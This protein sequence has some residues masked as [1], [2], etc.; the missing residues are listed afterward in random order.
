MAGSWLKLRHDLADAP[1]IRRLARA[2]SVTKDDVLGKL[3]RAWSWFD[4]HSH[5][6]RVAEETL[7]LV[8]E[9]VG[10]SGFAQALV[11][12]GWLAQDQAGIVIPNWD[13]H[14]S[15]TAKQRAL[16]ASR[17]AAARDSEP[18]SGTMPDRPPDPCPAKTRTREDERREELP[19]L[20][21]EGFAPEAWQRLRRAWNGGPGKPWKMVNPPPPAVE[22]LLEADWVE[23]YP[24]GIAKLSKVGFFKTP[25]SLR[26]FCSSDDRKGRFLDRL[27]GGEFDDKTAT[28]ARGDF[29]DAPLP[30]K[31]WTGPAEEARRAMLAKTQKLKQEAIP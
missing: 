9:I 18:V 4:R 10:H 6:G 26:Q 8:D 29:G 23:A 11:S 21:R 30:P 2:C 19:P 20:P 12:V 27:L 15:E 1:E 24:A 28:K 13:R 16:D 17:K 31:V 22:R 14:N 7:D 25:V 5:N 3:F